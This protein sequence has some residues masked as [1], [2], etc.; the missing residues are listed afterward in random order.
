MFFCYVFKI[1]L[2]CSSRFSGS[3]VFAACFP[4]VF[5]LHYIGKS[6]DCQY[7][8]FDWQCLNLDWQCPSAA[9][10]PAPKNKKSSLYFSQILSKVTPIRPTPSANRNTRDNWC[11]IVRTKYLCNITW[12]DACFNYKIKFANTLAHFVTTKNEKDTHIR[13]ITRQCAAQSSAQVNTQ[14]NIALYMGER[15]P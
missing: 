6:S 8:N 2:V 9:F 13:V 12:P 3:H 4:L 1:A 15:G 5:S 10:R 11:E 14:T 7:F